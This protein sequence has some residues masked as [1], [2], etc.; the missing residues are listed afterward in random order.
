MFHDAE[1]M[2][3]TP[4]SRPSLRAAVANMI[5]NWPPEAYRKG[6]GVV[7]GL[8][9]I[10]PATL[11]LTD[12][13]LIEEV[14]ITRSEEFV[15]DRFQSRALSSAFSRKSLFFAEG[16]D[17]RWQRRAAAPA[18]R[19]EK[20]LDL[21]PIFARH[22]HAQDEE[23]RI[24]GKG[25]IIDVAP[26][27]S[28]LTFA[29]IRQAVLGRGAEALDQQKFLSALS[30]RVLTIAWRFLLARMALPENMPFPGSRQAAAGGRW[31]SEAISQLLANRRNEGDGSKDI[32]ALLLSAKDPETGR[33]MGDAELIANLYMLMVA[34]HE[35]MATALAWTLWLLAKDQATQERLRAEIE[36]R[37]GQRA[38]GPEDI[39][40]LTFTG[41]SRINAPLP[42]GHRRR[43]RAARRAKT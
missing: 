33:A 23:W 5:E 39:D 6:H 26:A 37:A 22:A 41:P 2:P 43:P 29:I 4:R 1:F 38:I 18:F 34:G 3:F 35:T 16:A 24:K 15:R 9:P 28:K 7:S 36:T 30:P 32:L 11:L 20:L 8:W 12:P 27:M 31:L 13:V 17:W 25:L 19:H 40:H 14:L 10:L 21:V 42:A